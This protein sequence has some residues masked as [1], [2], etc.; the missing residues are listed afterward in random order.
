MKTPLVA[1][2]LA[3]ALVASGAAPQSAEKVTATDDSSKAR[4]EESK[5]GKPVITLGMTP[6]EVIKVIGRPENTET[7][8]TPAGKGEQW[9]YRR[10]AREWTQQ[11][12]AT[13]QMVPAFVGLGMPNDG[14]GEVA[15][16]VN[17]TE[18]V[19]LY[20]VSSLLF[21]EGRLAAA[22]QWTEKKSKIE[23]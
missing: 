13:V 9:I 12:A 11:N 3:S 20:Q 18:N 14:I 1:I 19:K 2:L 8:D 6:D 16:P 15:V 4:V 22:K 10:L 5:T 7:V 23:N 21:I 17:H